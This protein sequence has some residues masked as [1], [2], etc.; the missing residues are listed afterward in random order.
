[1][2]TTKVTLANLSVTEKAIH[3]VTN[4]LFKAKDED[5]PAIAK[6]LIHAISNYLSS[7]EL[8]DL[9]IDLDSLKEIKEQEEQLQAEND[10]QD[11][12]DYEDSVFP[13]Q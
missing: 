13:K 11:D 9:I 10:A 6:D 4:A 8:Y 12:R 3:E 1:M 7:N 2:K 5:K